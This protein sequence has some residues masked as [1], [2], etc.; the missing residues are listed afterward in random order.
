MSNALTQYREM[1]KREE[2]EKFGGFYDVEIPFPIWIKANMRRRESHV[3]T[4]DPSLRSG[5]QWAMNHPDNYPPVIINLTDGMSTDGGGEPKDVAQQNHASQR[6]VMA[7]RCLLIYISPVS[8]HRLY[9]ILTVSQK[10]N[11]AYEASL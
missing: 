4:L 9:S 1:R 11:D 7:T 6:P 5:F 2:I 3:H 8:T 10:C